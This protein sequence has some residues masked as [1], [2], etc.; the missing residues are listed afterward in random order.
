[1]NTR[2]INKYRD[3]EKNYFEE[4]RVQ[5]DE[6]FIE[7]KELS[8]RMRVL[9]TGNG[10]PL[11]FVHGA[12]ASGAIWMPLVMHLKGYKNIII[13]R[14]GCGLSEKTSYKDLSRHQLQSIM[15]FSIDA[16]LDHF[17]L[18]QIPI[19]SSSFGSGLTLL[20]A[21][22]RSERVSKLVIEGCPALINGARVPSFMKPM[23]LPGLKWLIPRLP[24]TVPILKK[25]MTDLGHKYPIEHRVI[26]N[27]F[28]NWYKS[29]FNNTTTQINEI[30][31]ITKAYPIGKVNPSFILS[32]EELETIREPML[33]LWSKDDPFGGIGTA[34]RLKAKIKNASLI[35]FEGRGHLPWLDNP[36]LH[37]EEIKK[38]I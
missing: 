27:S 10:S 32:D 23:L 37:A 9:T 31:M 7:I 19:I 38:F 3:S 26:P 34:Q 24:T 21:L 20:Y 33:L 16:V 18:P 29:L 22:K 5:V 28:I 30:G 1:M 15:V 2:K 14:P 35:T 25:I 8:I 12:P 11:L 4:C 36:E 17:K 13:D 6:H